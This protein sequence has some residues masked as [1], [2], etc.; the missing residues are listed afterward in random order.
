MLSSWGLDNRN[1]LGE[2]VIEIEVLRYNHGIRLVLPLERRA[3]DMEPTHPVSGSVTIEVGVTRFSLS[4]C[5]YYIQK[6]KFTTEHFIEKN[7]IKM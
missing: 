7:Y 1:C 6:F 2:S 5:I 3:I 4:V